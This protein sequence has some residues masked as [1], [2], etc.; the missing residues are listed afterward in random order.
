MV[1]IVLERSVFSMG[2]RSMRM[3][4]KAFDIMNACTDDKHSIATIPMF[5][6]FIHIW[7][8]SNRRLSTD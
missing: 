2:M 5:K 6:S 1:V 3:Y 4:S 8:T 7:H